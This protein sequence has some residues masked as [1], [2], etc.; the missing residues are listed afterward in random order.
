MKILL[1]RY[2]IALASAG[3]IFVLLSAQPPEKPKITMISFGDN[4]EDKPWAKN[5]ARLHTKQKIEQAFRQL[6]EDGFTVIYWRLLWEG[7]ALDEIEFYSH[8]VQRETS[9]LKQEF[10]GTPYAWDPHELR[11]PIEVAHRLGMKL[12]AWIVPYNMGAPPGAFAEAGRPP[13][14]VQF[15]HGLIY[16]TQFPYQAKFFRKNPQYQLVDRKGD[17]YHYGVLEWAYPEARRYWIDIVEEILLKYDVDGIYMD[18]RTECMAPDFA[19]Q[20]GFN[21]PIVQEYKRRHGVNILEQDFDLEKWRALRGEYFTLLL[22]ELSAV[23][24]DQKKLLSLGTYRGDYIGFPL[25]N[26]KLEWRK[27]IRERTIDELH[28]DERGWA[29]GT[30]GYGY[31][32]DGETDRGLAPFEETVREHYAPLCRQHGVKLYFFPALNRWSGEWKGDAA[33]MREFDGIILSP[34][35]R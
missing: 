30:H 6:K 15:P 33:A 8:R 5:H 19:D 17:R 20:F 21:Q 9:Q 1:F 12:Y 22:R 23:I 27:W 11:W 16:E 32:T 7:M 14:S 18:T 24:H 34:T 2:L 13:W 28:L 3:M 10:E 35:F 25:G 29:W 4:L 31:L 26:M